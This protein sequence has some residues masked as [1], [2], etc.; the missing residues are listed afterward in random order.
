ME[1][2]IGKKYQ[3]K[4][5][6]RRPNGWNGSGKIGNGAMDHFIGKIVTIRSIL[7]G[8]VTIKEDDRHSDTG[9]GS[10]NYWYFNPTDFQEIIE[11]FKFDEE[12]FEI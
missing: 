3:I 6:T 5:F 7:G 9:A 8:S 11:S 4:N 2:I 12:L 1:L 10:K